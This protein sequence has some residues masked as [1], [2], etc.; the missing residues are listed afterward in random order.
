MKKDSPLKE[1]F[2]TKGKVKDCPVYDLHGHMGPFG[3][4]HFPN[5]DLESMIKTMDRV[6]VKMLVFSHHA[7]LASPDIGNSVNI[8]AVR[9]YPDKLRAY[10][11]INP[12]YPDIIKKD[13]EVFEQHKDV[14][15]GF[16]FHADAHEYPIIG[17]NY[18]SAWE[19]AENKKLMVLLHTWGNSIY[20]GP[21]QI[22]EV[23]KKYTK[24]K[25]L[26]G[27]SC[28]GEWDKA[29]TLAKDFPNIYLELC[30]VMDNRGVLDKFVEKLGSERII[31]GTDFPWFSHYYYIG[32]VLGAEITDEDCRNIFYRNAE[33]LIS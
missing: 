17:K 7:S 31:F 16:K 22:R 18:H 15:V 21:D 12:N 8:D 11:V 24:A 10:C 23:A 14:F 20:N 33:K 13:L 32:A 19:I 29:I 2:F 25:I 4:A 9:K 5:S 27:H 30:A 28:H 3:G 6:G 26:L 1:Q